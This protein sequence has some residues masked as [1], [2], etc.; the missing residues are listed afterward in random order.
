MFI[1][2]CRIIMRPVMSQA[3]YNYF[4]MYRKR[5]EQSSLEALQHFYWL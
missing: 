4:A 5:S 1:D 3:I 2:L